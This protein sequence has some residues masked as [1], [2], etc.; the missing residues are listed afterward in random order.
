[1]A[2]GQLQRRPDGA[3]VDVVAEPVL[4]DQLQPLQAVP[5]RRGEQARRHGRRLAAALLQLREGVLVHEAEH[6]PEHLHVDAL[7]P[8][9]DCGAWR[10]RE[11]LRQEG[12]RPGGEDTP[13]LG[14][15][16]P[17]R[18]DGLAAH[19][20]RHVCPLP[21]R[22]EAVEVPAHVR[23]RHRDVPRRRR[24]GSGVVPGGLLEDGDVAPDPEGVVA[25]PFP[26]D[27]DDAEQ[28]RVYLIDKL[29]ISEVGDK[30]KYRIYRNSIG[31]REIF[32]DKI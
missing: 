14:E 3:R 24:C 23:R 1:M 12:Q 27:E 25:E 26:G 2:L 30:R 28:V 18:R 16:A 29:K 31:D 32:S 22:E 11:E 21:A 6:G 10:W 9:A 15:D 19:L 7:N 20:E 17:V 8:H 5:V 13:P 4:A